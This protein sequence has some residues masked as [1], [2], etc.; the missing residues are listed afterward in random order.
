MSLRRIGLVATLLPV[1]AALSASSASASPPTATMGTVSEVSYSSAHVTGEVAGRPPS[2]VSSFEYSTDDFEWVTGSSEFTF[3]G[4]TKPVAATITGLRGGTRYFVRLSANNFIEPI[5]ISPGPDPEFTTLPVDPPSVNSIDSAGEVEYTRAKVTGKVTR[6]TNPDHAFDAV[7]NFEYITDA[8]YGVTSTEVDTLTIQAAGGS[9]GLHSQGK[10]SVPIPFDASAATVAAA[11]EGLPGV[12]AGN[13]SVSGGPGSES[14]ASPY[15]ITFAGA[16]AHKNVPK[17]LLNPAGLTG[18]TAASVVETTTQGREEGFE[19]APQAGCTPENQIEK[20]GA[21]DV[22][23]ELTGL[24]P[25]TKYHLRLSASNAGGSDAKVAADFTTLTPIPAPTVVETG[26]ASEV[27]YTVAKVGGKIHRPTGVDPTLDVS[28]SFEYVTAEQFVVNGFE[29]AAQTGCALDGPIKQAGDSDVS[30]E[31]GGLTPGTEYHLRLTASNAGGS[32]SKAAAATFI[33][34]GSVPAPSIV[35]VNPAA[36]VGFS[37]ATLSGE[38]NR[39]N[40]SDPALEVNCTFEYISDAAFVNSTE[41]DKLTIQATGGSFVLF[42][43][44]AESAPIAFNASAAAVR[45]ALEAFPGIGAGNVSVSGGPGDVNGST[46]YLISFAGSLVNTNVP[47]IGQNGS[48]LTGPSVAADLETITQGHKEGFEGAAQSGCGPENPVRKGGSSKVEATVGLS[49]GTEYHQRLVISN[50]GGSDVEA[51]PDFKT[52]GPQPLPTGTIEE[53]SNITA[54]AAHVSGSVDPHGTEPSFQGEWI[55]ECTPACGNNPQGQFFYPE[56]EVKPVEADLI[57]LEPN[58]TYQVVLTAYNFAGGI[59]HSAPASF[60]T[61]QVAPAVSTGFATEIKRRSA[62]INGEVNPRN[63]AVTYQ[64]EWGLDESY[65]NVVP[66]PAE[67]LD[68]V[69]NFVHAVSAPLIGLEEGTTYHFRLSATV[70]GTEK[71]SQGADHT[72][73]TLSSETCPNEQIRIETSSLDLPE[74]RGYEMVSPIK[75]SGNDAGYQLGYGG[76]GYSWSTADGNGLIYH[77]RGTVGEEA[78]SGVEFYIQ[79][80]RGA[81]GW[82]STGALPKGT[83]PVVSVLTNYPNMLLFNPDLSRVFWVSEGSFLAELPQS[84]VSQGTS[85]AYRAGTKAADPIE[86]ISRAAIPDQKPAIGELHGDPIV[87]GGSPDLETVYFWWYPTLMAGDEVRAANHGWGLYEYSDGVLKHAGT[88]PDGSQPVGG[89]APANTVNGPQGREPEYVTSEVTRGDVT[90]DGSGLFFVSPDPAS[91]QGPPELYFHHG[92][93]STLVSRT[94]DGSPAPS[95]AASTSGIGTEY[96][97]A[98]F[99]FGSPDG[100]TA[101]FESKDALTDA[102]PTDSSV[103]AYRYDV[104]ADAITYLPGVGNA[105]IVA[106]SDDG[107]RFLFDAGKIGLWDDGTVKTVADAGRHLSPARATA[108]GSVFV[109]L[110]EGLEGFHSGSNFYP[111]VYRYN[112]DL[113]QLSCVSCPPAEVTPSG[114][115]RVGPLEAGGLNPNFI[116]SRDGNRIFFQS[117]DPFVP[118]DNNERADVYEW[119]PGGISLISTGRNASDSLLVGNDEEGSN[120]FFSTK[121]DIAPEDNDGLYDIYDARVDG[122]FK[123][124][125]AVIPCS[126]VDLCHGAPQEPATESGGGSNQFVIKPTPKFTAVP[127][128]VARGRLTLRITAPVAATVTASGKGLR[129]TV[130]ANTA[131][132]TYKLSL[133]LKPA[134]KKT[135]RKKSETTVRI[136]LHYSP[137]RGTP[138]SADVSLNVKG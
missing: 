72:F 33:T 88:L 73:K 38:V 10:E 57:G 113:E 19:G 13:V 47:D 14:G 118:R 45:G 59:T 123:Q 75:K 28:C 120:V 66:V 34:L 135:L 27:Q 20:A 52:N 124:K 15:T 21:S 65:G 126:G 56:L 103:K 116:M 5:G 1:V 50:G 133:P 117:P 100:K 91:G 107:S 61:P 74:C 105:T 35:K 41:V 68:G 95:G 11:L 110:A 40:G 77:T 24:A 69:D 23:A 93:G 129:T 64:F 2:T 90:A 55:I 106:A 112:T 18:S 36:N 82:K 109:F 97:G 78:S 39:A 92:E 80:H 79:A 134:L 86:W 122:G 6:P 136:H 30:A 7:C 128:R 12:G 3:G 37:L 81:T 43:E 53:I 111:Q 42:F 96:G 114:G 62:T 48:G 85:A 70:T 9:F 54:T 84:V 87:V 131:P 31:L 60:T 101:F 46:P 89:S 119:T 22:S 99:V 130:H 25:G 4:V 16:L 71:T 63:S 102:A 49:A 121:A 127:G 125:P 108:S 17:V 98:Q 8:E 67:A 32:N 29:G 94:A 104:A 137:D 44:G 138:S 26:N 132:A 76:P 83:Q 58:T 115:A 51:G